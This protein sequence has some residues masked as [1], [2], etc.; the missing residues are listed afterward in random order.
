MIKKILL[1]QL[2]GTVKKS[3]TSQIAI[4]MIIVS[5]A[6]IIIGTLYMNYALEDRFY[7]NRLKVLELLHA[8][9][10][11]RISEKI[12][13]HLTTIENSTQIPLIAKEL[14]KATEYNSTTIEIDTLIAEHIK[15][16]EIGRASCRERV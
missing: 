2:G 13:A 11:G 7:Q 6:P 10:I 16:I 8:Q 9:A 4:Y 15:K 1:K 14:R 5:L 3:I 12:D